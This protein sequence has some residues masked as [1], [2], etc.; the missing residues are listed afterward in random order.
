MRVLTSE[1][2]PSC[3]ATNVTGT[4]TGNPDAFANITVTPVALDLLNAMNNMSHQSEDCLTVNVWTKPQAGEAKK[5]VM[6]WIHG[7]AFTSGKF[8]RVYE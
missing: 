4:D 6:V 7:G 1:Q 5:A 3:L 8:S 2:G